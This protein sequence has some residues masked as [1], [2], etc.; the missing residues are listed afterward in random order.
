MSIKPYLK[1]ESS[2]ILITEFTSVDFA[3]LP[4]L[5]ANSNT[6]LESPVS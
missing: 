1:E 2:N 3:S 6:A 4:N 5:H